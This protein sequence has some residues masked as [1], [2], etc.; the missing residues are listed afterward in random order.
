MAEIGFPTQ[1]LNWVMACVSSVSYS[2]LVNDLPNR[3]FRARKGLKQGDPISPFFFAIGMEYLLRSLGSLKHIP[4]FNFHPRC[5]KLGITHLMFADYL[6]MYLGVPLTTRKLYHAECK[7]L[8][9]KT[10]SRIQSWAVK[11]LSY[12]ARLQLVKLVLHGFQLY[13]CEIYVLPTK[14]IKEIQSLCRNFLWTRLNAKSKK[15]HVAWDTICLKKVCGGWN[16][17]NMI[18]IS[19]SRRS[20]DDEVQ[21]VAH[22]SHNNSPQ[23]QLYTMFFTETLCTDDVRRLLIV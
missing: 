22:R 15:A 2:I 6:L 3:P 21:L 17:K 23:A 14:V 8:I 20:F 12:A 13:W 1:F 11:K 5:E 9:E 7:A 18:G 19:Y 16:I 4:N 10:V